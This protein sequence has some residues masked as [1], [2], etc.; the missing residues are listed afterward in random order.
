MSTE[1]SY[2]H[3]IEIN[4]NYRVLH[5]VARNITVNNTFF[6]ATI[7]K[8]LYY[9]ACREYRGYIIKYF[10]NCCEKEGIIY[11]NKSFKNKYKYL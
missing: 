3:R 11:R 4:P 2:G 1:T 9:V 7:D 8:V 10:V 5:P 6:F